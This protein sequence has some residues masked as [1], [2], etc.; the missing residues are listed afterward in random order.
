MKGHET[1]MNPA[2]ITGPI[3]VIFR[4]HL[5]YMTRELKSYGF[6]WVQFEFLMI[7]YHH[8]E[9]VSQEFLAKRLMVSKATST[10][11]IQKLEAEGYVSRERDKDDRRA[12]KVYLTEKG[13]AMQEIIWQKLTDWVEITFSDFTPEE[14]ET[15]RLM[16]KKAFYKAHE[17]EV[18]SELSDKD[19]I[20]CPC[21]QKSI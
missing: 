8:K 12:Y 5:A 1:E 9:G 6:G 11:A 19:K 13:K 15:F 3:A 17:L 16:L 7:L 21:D 14:K 10:R 2:D 18:S 20:S 4:N